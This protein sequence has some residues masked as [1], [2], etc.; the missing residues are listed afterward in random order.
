MSKKLLIIS[1]IVLLIMSGCINKE[2]FFSE[3]GIFTKIEKGKYNDLDISMELQKTTFKIGEK[4][5]ALF[6]LKNNGQDL[7]NLDENGFDA[8]IYDLDGTLI[9]YI[10]ENRVISKPVNLGPDVSFIES[11]DWYIDDNVEPGKYYLVGY[12]KAEVTNKTSGEK[13]APYTIMT[14][15]LTITIE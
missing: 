7:I 12:V 3:T 9:T 10:R 8:G 13:I 6:M 4:I 11:I 5:D 14:K 15:S 1:L 2:E